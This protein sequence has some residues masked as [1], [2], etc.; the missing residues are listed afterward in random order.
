MDEKSVKELALRT[1]L[2]ELTGKKQ[3]E[4][5]VVAVDGKCLRFGNKVEVVSA[6][7]AS[8]YNEWDAKRIASNIRAGDAP[9]GKAV[10]L[11]D[12]INNELEALKDG[13]T[14]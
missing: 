9:A 4:V 1:A 12:A 7:A 11:V 8:R 10:L 14:A 13:C 6:A 2:S 5:F 3:R